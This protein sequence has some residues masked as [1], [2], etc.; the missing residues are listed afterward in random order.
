LKRGENQGKGGGKRPLPIGLGRGEN[1]ERTAIPKRGRGECRKSLKK[2]KV[3]GED[4]KKKGKR[5]E[6][7]GI[8]Q[9]DSETASRR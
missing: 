7:L 6:K 1:S 8:F 3:R 4:Y 9:S 5:G 2:K